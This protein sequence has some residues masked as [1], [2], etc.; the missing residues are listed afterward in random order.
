MI[1]VNC[2]TDPDRRTGLIVAAAPTGS[3][4]TLAGE[5][6]ASQI[7]CTVAGSV[8]LVDVGRGGDTG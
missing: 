2:L 1:R 8:L 3:R 5:V 7:G 4:Y 6:A